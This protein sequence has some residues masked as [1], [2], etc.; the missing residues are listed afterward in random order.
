MI[1]TGA[2]VDGPLEE[3]VS[4]AAQGDRQALGELY[5]RFAPVVRASCLDRYGDPEL[6]WDVCQEVFTIVLRDLDRLESP[7]RFV[8]WVLGIA[9]NK[10]A[11]TW[12]K[13]Q[14]L[15][16]HIRRLERPGFVEE[17]FVENREILDELR[18]AVR[19]LSERQR[20]AVHLFHVEGQPAAR[21]AGLLGV[22]L[23]SVYAALGT[24]RETLK[25]R[26]DDREVAY[27]PE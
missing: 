7:A 14:R 1:R 13:G 26:I 27:D 9:R 19:E 21:V 15:D 16:G 24:A 4:Q 12:R 3:I 20:L 8:P 6:A 25:R 18:E 10:L 2:G 22:S 17:A 23:R 11:D 5:D